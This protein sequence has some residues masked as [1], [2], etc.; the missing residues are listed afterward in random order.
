MIRFANES[1]I[2]RIKEL[3]GEA[4]G[5]DD[6]AK[7]YFENVFKLENTLVYEIDNGKVVSM[8]QRLP[9]Y[10]KNI[11]ES[12]YIYG[13]CTDIKYRGKGIM[14]KLLSYSEAI[15]VAE[16]KMAIFLVPENEGLFRFYEKKGYKNHFY[17]YLREKEENHIIALE[18][19]NKLDLEVSDIEDKIEKTKDFLENDDLLKYNKI[20][21]DMLDI[22]IYATKGSQHIMRDKMYFYRQISMHLSGDGKIFCAYLGNKLVGYTF[23]YVENKIYKISELV[24]QDDNIYN[25]LM[26]DLNNKF[27]SIVV[28][29]DLNGTIKIKYG[30]IKLLRKMLNVNKIIINLVYD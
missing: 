5:Y 26:G 30:C 19:S 25:E 10:I 12:T 21:D 6:F 3:W 7:W 4:F 20:A 2:T 28:L 1:D 24:V 9:Y 22:Y 27:S 15:D 11:G 14:G 18:S 13:A 8:L 29:N 16:G 23:G 17:K